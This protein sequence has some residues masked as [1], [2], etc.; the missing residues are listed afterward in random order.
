M[1]LILLYHNKKETTLGTPIAIG[2]HNRNN[3]FNIVFVFQILRIQAEIDLL[4]CKNI[5]R[6][7]DFDVYVAYCA[8]CGSKYLQ[9]LF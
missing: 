3:V 2:V 8:Y 6:H 1:T 5:G 4:S 9:G 7:F